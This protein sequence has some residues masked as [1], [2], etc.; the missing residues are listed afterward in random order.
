VSHFSD[1]I[2]LFVVLNHHVKRRKREFVKS[3]AYNRL[4][5][6]DNGWL[7]DDASLDN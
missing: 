5:A 1:A 3:L 4:S 7:A 6:L 2:T